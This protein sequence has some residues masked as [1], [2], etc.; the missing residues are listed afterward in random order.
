MPNECTVAILR[1][2]KEEGERCGNKE[3]IPKE[4]KRSLP[5]M[6]HMNIESI[7]QK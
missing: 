6:Y 2:L 4:K 1:T 5:I 7:V 3:Y